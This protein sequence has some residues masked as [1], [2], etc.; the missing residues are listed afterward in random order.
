[1]AI[2][3]QIP[4][5]SLRD[6][7][8]YTVSVYDADYTGASPVILKGGVRP[9]LTTEDDDSDMFADIRKT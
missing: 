9:F 1:M 5:K 6:G 8:L 2:H 4:F 3:W 7:T